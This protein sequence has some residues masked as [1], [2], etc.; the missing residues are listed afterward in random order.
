MR[1]LFYLFKQIIISHWF[2]FSYFFGFGENSYD[3]L[4]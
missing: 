3:L 4:S 2:F 1:V